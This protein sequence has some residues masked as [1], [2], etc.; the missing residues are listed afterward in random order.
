MVKQKLWLGSS[1]LVK[2]NLGHSSRMEEEEEEEKERG[3]KGWGRTVSKLKHPMASSGWRKVLRADE[4]SPVAFYP[5]RRVSLKSVKNGQLYKPLAQGVWQVVQI[6][7][8][9]R[10]QGSLH[11]AGAFAH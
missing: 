8:S 6:T 2:S 3:K 7:V 4:S 1:T 9:I 11:H 5:E 10:K